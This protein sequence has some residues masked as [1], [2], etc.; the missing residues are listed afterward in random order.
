M[1]YQACHLQVKSH[2][3]S[4]RQV[5]SSLSNYPCSAHL[6]RRMASTVAWEPRSFS[7]RALC[8]S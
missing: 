5:C 4:L 1:Q 2:G 3:L 7:S 8:W 6:F